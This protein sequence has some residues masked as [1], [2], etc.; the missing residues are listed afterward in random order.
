M[1][2]KGGLN[3][4]AHMT[5]TVREIFLSKSKATPTSL[6]FKDRKGGMIK[7]VSNAFGR[8]VKDLGFNDGIDD[9]RQRVYF[10]TLR[11]TF[12]SW[13]VQSGENLYTVKE[14]LGHST[15]AMT[16]RYSHLASKN[17]KD[18]VRK[19]EDSL[20]AST[21]EEGEETQSEAVE[22]N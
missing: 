5:G 12:A 21:K 3:R 20:K 2:S 15:M 10:H 9:P 19:L 18:A 6:V 22:G 8:A 11:H 13:L 16:E 7:E 17:L 14:L 4:T 1:D